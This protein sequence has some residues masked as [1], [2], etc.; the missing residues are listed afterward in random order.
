MNIH[1]YQAKSLLAK[2]GVAVPRGAVAYTPEEAESAA[3]DLG[4]PVWVVKS[5][6][7]AGGRGAGRF[8]DD[9]DGKGGVRVV[10]SV[11]EVKANA[12]QMLGHVLVT[13]QTGPAGK[14]V[15][16]LYIEEGC[17][18]A[19]ELYLGMLIDRA[20]SRVTLMASTEGGME[21]EEVAAEH[22]EKILKLAIDPA[23]GFM[24]FHGRK[25]AFGL[26]LEGKQVGAAVKFMTAMYN[27]FL[28]LDASIV[29]INPLVV[30][31]GGEVIAL[32]A[33][34]NFDDNALFRHKDVAEM[35]DEDEEDAMELEA[36]KHELNYIKLDGQV[37][38]MVNGAGL[39]MA[40]MDIIKL[41][42]SEP[43][44]FLDVGGGATK[45]RVTAA[46]KIILSDPNVE[47]ILVNIFGGIMRCDV[48][49]EGVVA[50]AREVKLHVPLVVRLEG[51][52]VELGKKILAE[53][54]LPIISADNLADAAEKVVKAVREA[55]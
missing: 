45:E 34:M 21:I 47:G 51:T 37:G 25:I 17:D 22:P 52:N 44:N 54:G 8:Q 28:S 48:I 32:D 7:H 50:A 33:K 10:K 9:P 19:R 12:G 18:I 23:V 3:R 42:G 38:C 30:T 6:I 53:S 29:E 35:R 20:T 27:A 2:F 43:A 14:E 11:D 36:A 31:G 13:K 4:G 26:G 5:Q 39:A 16:R 40:T 49:A 24:P 15:K 46:F 55:A 1:E 41:Y